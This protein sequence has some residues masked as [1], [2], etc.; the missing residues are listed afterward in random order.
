MWSRILLEIAAADATTDNKAAQS[1][2]SHGQRAAE[3]NAE[4][5]DLGLGICQPEGG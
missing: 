2:P 1:E 3:Y 5:C 4:E